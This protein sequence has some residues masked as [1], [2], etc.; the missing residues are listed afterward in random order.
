MHRP[1]RRRSMQRH[2][3]RMLGCTVGR[4]FVSVFYK[5]TLSAECVALDCVR[6]VQHQ[7]NKRF[8]VPKEPCAA[9]RQ[10]PVHLRPWLQNTCTRL[11]AL[12]AC[13]SW[14]PFAHELFPNMSAEEGLAAAHAGVWKSSS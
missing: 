12:C 4:C 3:E 7:N 8:L 14:D 9:A 11:G 6:V 10:N 13:T 5:T 2:P 1:A